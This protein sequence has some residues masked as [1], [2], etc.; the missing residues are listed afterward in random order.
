MFSARRIQRLAENC[1]HP[2]GNTSCDGC[3]QHDAQAQLK[4][5]KDKAQTK[6]RF[7]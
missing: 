3:A 1:Q 6:P 2:V 4:P 5:K 7:Q